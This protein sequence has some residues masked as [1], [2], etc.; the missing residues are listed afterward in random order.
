M[1]NRN[2]AIAPPPP[3]FVKNANFGPL[4]LQ[5]LILLTHQHIPLVFVYL[6]CQNFVKFEAPQ[7]IWQLLTVGHFEVFPDSSKIMDGRTPPRGVTRE[8]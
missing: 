7:T 1:E 6:K 3:K 2:M 8:N 5:I 4:P